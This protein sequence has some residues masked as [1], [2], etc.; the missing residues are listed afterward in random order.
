MSRAKKQPKPPAIQTLEFN[1]TYGDLIVN[2]ETGEV[3]SYEPDG[4]GVKF[5]PK[6]MA[7]QFAA[8]HDEGYH[9]IVKL[10]LDEWRAYCKEHHPKRKL[11]GDD[12]LMVGFWTLN[13]E[14]VE[15]DHDWR[16]QM[17]EPA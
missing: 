15:A 9:D 8:G 3:I 6:E 16:K 13:G 1:G 5:T 12:I 10:D 2:A 7:E 14:K 17:L 11:E 4:D